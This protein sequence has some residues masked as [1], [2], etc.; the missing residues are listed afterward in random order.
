MARSGCIPPWTPRY[1]YLD[2]FFTL[3]GTS[4]FLV[5]LA[6]D[7]WVAAR[8]LQ[9]GDYY[10]GG[11]VLGLMGFSSLATQ[12]FSWAWYRSDPKDLH[13]DEPRDRTLLTLHFLQL[14]Y[15][16]RCLHALKVGFR[17]CRKEAA[18]EIERS[19]AIFLSH[20][21]SLLRLFET[22][23]ES[24]PQLTLGIYIMLHMNKIGTI[25]MFGIC[26]S[27]ICIAWALL[28]YHQ[29]LRIFLSKTNKLGPL[30]SAVYFLW[31]F[32]LVC[33]RILSLA[34]F[35][36]LF[37]SYI[38]LHFFLFWLAMFI[39][40]TLQGTDLMEHSGFEWLYR[41][42]VAVILYF[43]WFNVA[44]GKTKNR[45]IIYYTFL[46][47]DS[48]LLACFWVWCSVPLSWDCLM[49]YVLIAAVTSY[50]LGILLRCIYYQCL[51]PTLQAASPV[52]SDEID[53]RQLAGEDVAVF[54]QDQVV[55]HINRRTY[56]LSRNLFANHLQDIQ[57]Q[58]NGSF[59]NVNL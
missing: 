36:D 5:D 21:I 16:Y 25:Q 44:E 53:F 57:C 20:D 49:L 3:M 42:V 1:R 38:F 8:Y 48:A 18:T 6:A 59:G 34:L 4:A 32:L 43:C 7:L 12:L 45:C 39:W 35:T 26:T 56:K 51:H 27:S 19:Y 2:L 28:D 41:V 37:P 23:L 33:P 52:T 13:A 30:S 10:W 24:A 11:L 55:G 31:N 29:S 40:V 17:V 9:A 46:A 58:Q 47:L 14:G 22:F 15:L 50:A 54:Q